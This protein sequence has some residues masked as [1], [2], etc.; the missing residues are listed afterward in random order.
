MARACLRASLVVAA[1]GAEKA[2]SLMKCA[3]WC[4]VGAALAQASQ[5]DF[6]KMRSALAEMFV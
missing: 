4:S 6:Q 2:K 5:T 1:A 3:N